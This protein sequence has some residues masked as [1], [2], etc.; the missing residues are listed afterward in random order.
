MVVGSLG[1]GGRTA[2]S[3]EREHGFGV[4]TLDFAFLDHDKHGYLPDLQLMESRGWLHLGSV[5]VADNVKIPGAPKYWTY[6]REQEGRMWRTVEH[7]THVEYQALV[8]D[9]VLDSDY[10]GPSRG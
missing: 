2:D 10:L 9:V 4:G 7:H 1:D 6:L 3:L 5:V 8:K